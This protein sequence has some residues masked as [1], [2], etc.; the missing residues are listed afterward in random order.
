[1]HPVKLYI[2]YVGDVRG[3]E[4]ND[5]CGNAVRTLNRGSTVL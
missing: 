4:K 2:V 1:M 3:P 5:T